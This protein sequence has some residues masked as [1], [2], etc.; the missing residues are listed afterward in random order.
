MNL[1]SGTPWCRPVLSQEQTLPSG[2]V[3][4]PENLTFC[5]PVALGLLCVQVA[6]LSSWEPPKIWPDRN[7]GFNSLAA[8]V[9]LLAALG[10]TVQV[11]LSV[12][13][14][15]I[16]ILGGQCHR[17]LFGSA[18]CVCGVVEYCHGICAVIPADT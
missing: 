8:W 1:L 13:F 14:W 12:V 15:L 16:W 3:L 6:P 7:V 2:L 4:C 9:I 10:R 11:F 17:S 5:L 18:S